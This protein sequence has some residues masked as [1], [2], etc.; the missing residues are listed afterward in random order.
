MFAGIYS[1]STET[2]YIIVLLR[3][4]SCHM[5]LMYDDVQGTSMPHNALNVCLTFSKFKTLPV[6]RGSTIATPAGQSSSL[7][8]T[9]VSPSLCGQ[10]SKIPTS[11]EGKTKN[12]PGAHIWYWSCLARPYGESCLISAHAFWSAFTADR[13]VSVHTQRDLACKIRA[14][15][16]NLCS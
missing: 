5:I 13:W 16:E 9:V 11:Q 15:Q 10:I 2:E 6:C 1:Y 3:W 14:S 12:I 4:E 8:F 7:A